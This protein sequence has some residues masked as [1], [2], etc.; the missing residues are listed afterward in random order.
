MTDGKGKEIG[1]RL[2]LE[3]DAKGNAT[4]ALGFK[5]KRDGLAWADR[6]G[7]GDVEKQKAEARK[8]VAQ[9]AKG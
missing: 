7:F 9:H 6:V 3:A 2:V 4:L 1:W 8:I 5:T